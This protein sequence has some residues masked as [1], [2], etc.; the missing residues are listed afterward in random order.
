M[1]RKWTAA[2]KGAAQHY[3]RALSNGSNTDYTAAQWDTLRAFFGSACLAC[4]ATES[5][6]VDH[7][8][9]LSVGGNN[10]IVN[11][12]PLCRT[13]NRAKSTSTIDY[14]DPLVLVQALEIMQ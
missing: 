4:G 7:V 11:L 1:R 13:C 3:R 6:T 2:E 10:T 5:L 14:R 8:V 9:P 12:Q